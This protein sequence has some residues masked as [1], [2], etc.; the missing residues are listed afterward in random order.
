MPA[1]PPDPQNLSLQPRNGGGGVSRARFP[2]GPPHLRQPFQLTPTP[3]PAPQETFRM[4]NWFQFLG[5][6]PQPLWGPG[7]QAPGGPGPKPLGPCGPG[8]QAPARSSP[9][10]EPWPNLFCVRCSSGDLRNDICFGLWHQL[11]SVRPATPSEV[12]DGLRD[13][14]DTCR[15]A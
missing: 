10:P 9:A 3:S 4:T 15:T 6:G 1:S 13:G 14:P 8:P 2:P 5:L 12:P 11:I 7:P